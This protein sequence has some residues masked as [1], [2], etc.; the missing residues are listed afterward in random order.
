M[1]RC[2]SSHVSDLAMTCFRDPI[3]S[4]TGPFQRVDCL[5]LD[6]HAISGMGRRISSFSLALWVSAIHAR[7]ETFSPLLLGVGFLILVRCRFPL[8]V[9]I[10]RDKVRCKIPSAALSAPLYTRTRRSWAKPHARVF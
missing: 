9:K 10:K 5:P 1:L 8:A 4:R 2:R 3:S 6:F 7:E